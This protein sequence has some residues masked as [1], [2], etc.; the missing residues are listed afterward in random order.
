M[1]RFNSL[2]VQL[3]GWYVLLLGLVLIGFS[4]ALYLILDR[5]LDD[6]VDSGLQL[7]ATQ[8]LGA[9]TL[10][11]GQPQL[12][13]SESES[14]FSSLAERGLLVRLATL[15]GRVVASEGPFAALAVP[16]DALAAARQGQ[17]H[18]STETAPQGDTEVRLYTV[19]YQERGQVYGLVQVGQSLRE[20]ASLQQQLLLVLAV[21]L[22]LTLICASLGGSFLANRAL[23]P[24]DRITRAA[25]HIG[26]AD[27]SQRLNL[28]LSDDEVGRLARTFDA[29]LARLDAAF[30][31]QRQFTAD[32]SHE[33]R[34][35]LAIMKGDI[36]VALNGPRDA[37]EYQ[38]VLTD[39]EEEVDRLTRMVEDLLLLA[40]ADTGQPLLHPELVDL[41]DVLQ[42]V[43]DQV[44]TLAAA[45]DVALTV[46]TPAPLP[47]LGDE[48]KLLRLFLNLLDNAVKYTPAGGQIT[49]AADGMDAAMLA[50]TVQ[51]NGPGIPPEQLAHIFE[52]FYRADTVRSRVGGGT[53]LGLAIARWIA[54]AHG[55]RI[56]ADSRPGAGS[57]FTVWLP[58]PPP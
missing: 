52:R 10:V 26:A 45:K 17:P 23:A 47:V 40:R 6:Q 55:G 57:T 32:A 11:D 36:G 18:F 25:Q 13:N 2:R 22:P 49:V 24:I 14:D 48:D 28:A 51:D 46:H 43:G 20:V 19:P 15:D 44:R 7:A 16:F 54:E 21:V 34:T 3:T 9:V 42:V 39:L 29:M 31:R 56:A 30:A 27:L 35:P 8:A 37:A 4:G 33:L 41:T 53:G 12:Q 5:A 38:R 1:T 50:V 58:R